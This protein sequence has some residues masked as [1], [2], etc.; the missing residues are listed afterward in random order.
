MRA[1]FAHEALLTMEPDADSGAPGAAITVELCGHWNHEP[2][3]PLAPH[4]TRVEQ[5]EGGVRLRIL[6]AAEANNESSVREGITRALADG[7]LDE[8]G[9]VITRWTLRDSR[10]GDVL[11]SEFEH[12]QE[13]INH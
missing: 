4:H 12:A 11:A 3:C 5:I 6:F 13:L 8:P 9:G 10:R 2:P 7:R 1:A